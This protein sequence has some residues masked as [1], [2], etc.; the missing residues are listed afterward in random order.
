M[1]DPQ[2]SSRRKLSRAND[3]NRCHQG[4]L[5]TASALEKI[6]GEAAE[7]REIRP[8]RGRE[9]SDTPDRE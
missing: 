1:P 4:E 8:P 9:R 5:R 6:L 3:T 7:A 2:T